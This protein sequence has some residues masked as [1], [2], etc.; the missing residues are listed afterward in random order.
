[1]MEY[2]VYGVHGESSEGERMGKVESRESTW[3][4]REGERERERVLG[5]IKYY[6]GV[7]YTRLNYNLR[8]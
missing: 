3:R 5:C 6:I 1:M 4:E 2:G 7:I 8:L